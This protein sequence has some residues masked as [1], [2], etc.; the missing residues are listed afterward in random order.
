MRCA[1]LTF[2]SLPAATKVTSHHLAEY[3]VNTG[4]KVIYIS[5]AISPFHLL[6]INLFITNFKKIINILTKAID[7]DRDCISI[8]PLTLIPIRNNFPFNSKLAIELNA[9]SMSAYF[10]QTINL[11]LKD[12]YFL[13]LIWINNPK[14]YAVVKQTKYRKLVYS[15]ED[16]L[17]EFLAM[18]HSLIANH[19]KLIELADVVTVTSE[20]LF[21][22]IQPLL[23]K[24][25]KLVLLRNGVDLQQFSQIDDRYLE[26]DREF[27]AISQPRIIYVGAISYWFDFDLLIR[28]AN[29]LPDY[30]F[31]IVGPADVSIERL[32]KISNI[33]LLGAKP[34]AIIQN[35]LH[36]SDV[37]IIPFLRT[38]LI[39]S[40]NPIK[41]YEY[42][43]AGLPVI[44]TTW[45]ELESLNSP[46]FLAKNSDEFA[47]QIAKILKE[48]NSSS[49]QNLIHFAEANSWE[50]RFA[51]LMKILEL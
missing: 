5:D 19:L 17:F 13:D 44:S 40:V 18:P 31:V 35:Y 47:E 34:H 45:E 9:K 28:V 10:R 48:S 50:S 21:R 23:E 32:Q 46:A 49:R 26:S 43:A 39:E 42:M 16:D 2:N 33:Y 25:S 15:I 29:M 6:R 14:Y 51:Q 37:G 38:K 20:P 27:R 7:Y 4:F 24:K 1:I 11:F 3:L 36:E 22:Q 12:R 30:N 41:L 8:I